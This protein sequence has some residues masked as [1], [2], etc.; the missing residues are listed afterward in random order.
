MRNDVTVEFGEINGKF[1]A[2]VKQDELGGLIEAAVD[3]ILLAVNDASGQ[4]G[5]E[6][7][8]ENGVV[9]TDG[10]LQIYADKNKRVFWVTSNG[11]IHLN[12]TDGAIFIDDTILQ[13][14]SLQMEAPNGITVEMSTYKDGINF[15]CP[16]YVNH[17]KI[18][19]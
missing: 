18:S 6:I 13:K 1:Q 4:T 8:R 7:T 10:K 17:N 2:T 15:D 5:L 14:G 11:D 3:H 12:D 16:I 19:E 9:I